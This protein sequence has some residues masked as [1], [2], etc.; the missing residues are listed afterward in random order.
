M[1]NMDIGRILWDKIT[2]QGSLRGDS[3]IIGGDLSLTIR[4]GEF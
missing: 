1:G 2:Q 3:V 4:V